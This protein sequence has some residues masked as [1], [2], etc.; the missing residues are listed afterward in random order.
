VASAAALLLASASALAGWDPAS[1]LGRIALAAVVA[2]LIWQASRTPVGDR[3]LK[4]FA[5]G[6][7]L[8]ALW[9]SWQVLV[10]F[11]RA[12]SVVSELPL[13]MQD[14]AAERLTSGR[15]F[16]SLL[17]PSHLAVLLATA[18]PVLSAAVRRGWSSAV[19]LA[20]CVLCVTGLILTYSPIG[21]GL[22]AAASLAVVARNRRWL[23]L[24]AVALLV[25]A[26]AAAF[27]ARPDLTNFR[28]LR[29][30][31]DNWRTASWLWSTSPVAGIGLG[32]YGQ[33]SQAVPFAVGNRPAHAHSLPAEWA[34]ELGLSGVAAAALGMIAIVVLVRRLWRL[35]PGLAVAVAVVPLHN[36]VDFSLFTSGVAVPWAVLVGWGLAATR[37][38]REQPAEQRLRPALVTAAAVAV[39]LVALHATSVVVAEAAIGAESAED[40]Y[41]RFAAAHRLAPWRLEAVAGCAIGALDSSQ[42]ELVEEAGRMLD[43]SRWLRPNSAA[44]AGLASRLDV[45][46]GRPSSAVAE[47]WAADRAQP[48]A[49]V[50]DQHLEALIDRLTPADE[51]SER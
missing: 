9:G 15:A 18:L 12:Q 17:L 25:V 26:M 38:P 2:T 24:A 13:H 22:A 8:L 41:S 40:R 27:A 16:A 49:A 46:R 29:L 5:F 20:G 43:S 21:I 4:I 30:R 50:H 42:P 3:T 28:P 34:A 48:F 36:L 45:A 14:N 32:G 7:A 35:Q 51:G 19:W 11:E 23:V 10:G 6:L 44:L 31:V 37:R 47:A 33:A 1:G 39:A